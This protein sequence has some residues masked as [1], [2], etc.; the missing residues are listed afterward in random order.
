MDRRFRSL[1]DDVAGGRRLESSDALGLAAC[2]DLSG[3]MEAA[4]A[5]RDAGHQAV[6]L[7]LA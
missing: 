4:S 5:L 7:I 6:D 1:L 3:L 2:N